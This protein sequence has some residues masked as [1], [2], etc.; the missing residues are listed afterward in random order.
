MLKTKSS[1]CILNEH[2]D[3]GD[4]GNQI[5]SAGEEDHMGILDGPLGSCR[6]KRECDGLDVYPPLL[7]FFSL[8]FLIS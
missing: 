8:F 6:R 2:S 7:L 5:E 3:D 1:D 4:T